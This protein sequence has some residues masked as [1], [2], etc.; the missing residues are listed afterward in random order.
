L[1][2]AIEPLAGIPAGLGIIAGDFSAT[3]DG[4]LVAEFPQRGLRDGPGND[5][6]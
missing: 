3:P 5:R 6:A 1:D 2:Q 4:A